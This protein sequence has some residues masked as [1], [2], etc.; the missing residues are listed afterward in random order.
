MDI[1]SQDQW[2]EEEILR[3]WGSDYK[4]KKRIIKPQLSCTGLRLN[5]TD[6]HRNLR[7]KI[8]YIHRILRHHFDWLMSY[9]QNIWSQHENSTTTVI[10]RDCNI[11]NQAWKLGLLFNPT[12]LQYTYSLDVTWPWEGHCPDLIIELIGGLLQV[13][14][15]LR[16]RIYCIYLFTIYITMQTRVH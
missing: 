5:W 16:H 3:K 10:Q 1:K 12:N 11:E 7:R 13:N 4:I 15:S 9:S 14:Y 8:Q 2:F 6:S